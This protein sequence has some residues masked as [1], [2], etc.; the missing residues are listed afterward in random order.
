[1]NAL[2]LLKDDHEKVTGILEKIDE[3]TE[4]AIQSREE[5]FK[6]DEIEELGDRLQEAKRVQKSAMA[7]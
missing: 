4:R 3:T 5:L 2:A 7:G 1:M 6:Q